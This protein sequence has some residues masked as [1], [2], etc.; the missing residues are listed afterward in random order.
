MADQRVTVQ[1]QL[2]PHAKHLTGNIPRILPVTRLIADIASNDGQDSS[3]IAR[4]TVLA[5]VGRKSGA[6]PEP[7][8]NHQSFELDIPGRRVAGVR[9]QTDEVDYWAIRHD[10]IDRQFARVWTT[11]VTVASLGDM[12]KFAVR[13]DLATREAQPE[14]EPSVPSFVRAVADSPGLLRNG[15][16]IS[17]FPVIVDTED[18]LD[19]L[20]E[21]IENP[22][23]SR[24]VFVV[25][26]PDGSEDTEDAPVDPYALARR[27]IGLARVFVLPSSFSYKFTDVVG[28]RKFSVFDGA[29]RTFRPG[30]DFF[31]GNPFDHPLALGER[32]EAWDE[33]YGV[34]FIFTL[35]REAAR[36]S[37]GLTGGQSELPTFGDV[38]RAA[39]TFERQQ[40]EN[41]KGE[42]NLLQRLELAN[43]QIKQLEEDTESAIQLASGEEQARSRAEDEVRRLTSENEHL[44]YRNKQLESVPGSATQDTETDEIEIPVSLDQLKPWAEE[45]FEGKVDVNPRAA[46][47]A[48]NSPFSD[49]ELCYRA[50][51]LLADKYRTMKTDGGAEKRTEFQDGLAAL[52]LEYTKTGEKHLLMEKGREFIVEYRGQNRLLEWHL[53]NGG[54]TRDPARCFRLYFFW[55]DETEQVVIGSMPGHLDTRAT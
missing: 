30:C 15:R 33:Q 9:L 12:S 45:H 50:V 6:L 7:A 16:P 44:R 53:K 51:M 35:L 23:R 14:F 20:L 4:E 31:A 37:P 38:R 21:L 28:D 5:W 11:E 2:V 40:L 49:I 25:A 41:Q 39:L 48:K 22:D 27:T 19:D 17:Q 34:P 24:P 54:N 1:E 29:V 36:Y 8:R 13:L 46:R 10:D 55:D 52:G 18:K 3:H 43:R 42:K 32:I 47:A 26:L